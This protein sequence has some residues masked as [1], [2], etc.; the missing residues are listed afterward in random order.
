[1][2]AAPNGSVCLWCD[3]PITRK[4]RRGSEQKFCSAAHRMAFW[5]AARRWVA[6]MIESGSLTLEDLKRP[7]AKRARLIGVELVLS[8]GARPNASAR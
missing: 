6:R 5:T 1:M 8:E 4:H 3:R 7:S 2:S